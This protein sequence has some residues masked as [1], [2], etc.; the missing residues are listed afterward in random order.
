MKIRRI[1]VAVLLLLGLLVAQAIAQ[2][3]QR[4]RMDDWEALDWSLK[5]AKSIRPKNGFVPDEATAVKI[6][7]AAAIAQ[8]GEKRISEERPFRARLRGDTWT[9]QGT[10]HPEGVYG[11]TAVVKLSKTDGKILFMIHQY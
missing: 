5:D 7:E 1:S 2:Q 10:L 8:Y 9:V 3:P 11:G 6:A 4:K